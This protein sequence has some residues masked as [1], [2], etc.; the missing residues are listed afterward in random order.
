MNTLL[1]LAVPAVA[2]IIIFMLGWVGAVRTQRKRTLGRTLL[3]GIDRQ[4]GDLELRWVKPTNNRLVWGTEKKRMGTQPFEGIVT[5][6]HASAQ[7]IVEEPQTSPFRAFTQR[8]ANLL[9][10]QAGIERRV[11]VQG[12]TEFTLNS[13]GR[14]FLVD[15]NTLQTM[16]VSAKGNEIETAPEDGWQVGMYAAGVHERNIAKPPGG[17]WL[18]ELARYTPLIVIVV[19]VVL[20]GA[21]AAV[22]AKV[23]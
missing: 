8:L 6:G 3:I 14:A 12:G 16:R 1:I 9:R 23:H 18:E 7:T 22:A 20:V 4:R 5:P 19:G 13:T 11:E 21:I 15:R 2:L 17:S 10:E